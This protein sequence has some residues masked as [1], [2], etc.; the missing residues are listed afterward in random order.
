[1]ASSPITSWHIE[2]GKVETVTDFVFLDSKITADGNYEHEIKKHLV[3]GRKTMTKLDNI[4]KSR[5]IT[6]PVKIHIVKEQCFCFFVF[7]VFFNEC[8]SWTIK[9]T[10]I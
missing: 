7:C 1:M 3:F 4:L 6:F 9:K 8:E 2:G 10:E 5:D